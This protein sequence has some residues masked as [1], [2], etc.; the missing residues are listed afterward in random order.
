VGLAKCVLVFSADHGV[1]PLP[2]HVLARDAK[3][4]GGRVKAADM[5][6][7][8]TKAL[9]AAYGGLGKGETWFLRDNYGYHFR[10]ETLAVKKVT[11]SEAA[12]VMK[13]A[14]AALPYV[15][16]VYTRDELLATDPSDESMR[17]LM[18]RSYRA[19]GDRDVVFTFKPHF[20][21]KAGGGSSHGFPYDYDQH[22]PQ[23]WFGVGVPRGVARREAVGVDDIAPTLA[24]LLG[25]PAP[26][27]A[28]GK[29]VL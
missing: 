11:A 20:V 2:E 6:A 8:V 25:V 4:S 22:V 21:G 18:R 17:A 1:S 12:R 24:A 10:A 19:S 27:Q 29:R 13:G 15:A 26:A 3:A 9:N 28:Q 23:L 14:I 16:E 5:D 7:V